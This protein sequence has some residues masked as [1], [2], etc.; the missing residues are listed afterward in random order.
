MLNFSTFWDFEPVF[1]YVWSK[2]KL[3]A[4]KMKILIQNVEK[5][6]LQCPRTQIDAFQMN[7]F[8]W[9]KAVEFFDKLQS[10]AIRARPDWAYEFPDRTGPDTQICPTG[11]AGLDLILTYIFKQFDK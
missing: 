8:S 6:S 9:S 3:F 10:L 1:R 2:L 11:P 4:Q 5:L 7:I